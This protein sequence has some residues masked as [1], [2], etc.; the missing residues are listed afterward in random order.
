MPIYLQAYL[1]IAHDRV[2]EQKKEAGRITNV[3]LQ[4]KVASIFYYLCVVTLQYVAPVIICLYLALMYKTLGDYRW[5]DL[6]GNASNVTIV[7]TIEENSTA[8]KIFENSQS[9]VQEL[10]SVNK[11]CKCSNTW[12]EKIIYFC[13]SL[14]R[15]SQPKFIVDCLDLQLGG[16]VLRGLPLHRLA[17]FINHTLPNHRSI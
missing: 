7:S 6:F 4:K 2:E 11:H 16:L 10:K 3:D 12:I 5:T 1:N 14:W 17:C 9:P 13:L 8:E 15:S